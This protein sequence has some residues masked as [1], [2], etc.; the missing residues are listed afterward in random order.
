M[1]F[2]GTNGSIVVP[3]DVTGLIDGPLTVAVTL[4]N[5]AGNSYAT[6]L[7]IT[8]DTV[9]PVLNVAGVPSQYLNSANLSSSYIYV[10]TEVDAM[11][12]YN[13]TDGVHTYAGS[14][15]MNSSG[16]WNVPQGFTG[17]ND[18][19]V[20]LTL[21]STNPAGNPTVIIYNLIKDTVAP[22][23]SFGIAGTTINSQLATSNPTL[24]LSLA[25]TDATSG[26]YQV[27]LSSNGGSTYG[28]AQA[29]SAATT[30]TLTGA[31]GLYTIAVKV[32][33]AA[34]NSAVFTKTVRLDRTGPAT[35]YSVTAPTNAGSY[36]AGQA[37][38]LTYSASDVDNVASISALLDGTTSISTG[39]AFNT[40]TLSAGTHTVVITAR[41]GLG[42]VSTTTV[43]LTV[44]AT[45]GGL[46]TAVN[47]GV[48]AAKITS[49]SVATQLKSYLTSAQAA[50]NAN[51]H[52][53][54]KTYLASFVSLVTAQNG[55][56]INAAYAAL[57]IGWANDLIGRL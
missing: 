16:Q 50:L 13:L 25:F 39:V 2:V 22:A 54:A 35:T 48:T 55:V 45:V 24:S 44:H 56:T 28:T 31:D 52:A 57:L 49:S 27:A 17:L 19:R 47:D 12:S 3:L 14:K 32:F 30:L 51:N 11:V 5:G 38:T 42:N 33:D 1:D 23:G 20:T 6:T 40:E 7:A 9:A 15:A 53:S 18:G 26:L 21:T 10:N 36:D 8:K 37:V 29:Y 34:G 46:T 43:T 41:D 4:T